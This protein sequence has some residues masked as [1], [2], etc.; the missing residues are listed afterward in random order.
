[1]ATK[2]VLY[3]KGIFNVKIIVYEPGE[4]HK[5]MGF[6]GN[7][8][9][10]FAE[11]QVCRRKSR[12]TRKY[13]RAK[14]DHNFIICMFKH[15]FNKAITRK[16]RLNDSIHQAVKEADQLYE[17]QLIRTAEAE[18]VSEYTTCYIEALKEARQL[19]G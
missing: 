13:I 8:H 10:V 12:Q 5:V 16:D 4:E 18:E 3:E 9:E 1:M 6:M 14:N 7:I 15:M 2:K 17:K 19:T 11:V